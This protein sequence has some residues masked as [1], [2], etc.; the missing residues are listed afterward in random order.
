[1]LGIIFESCLVAH[2]TD[3]E[4]H[5]KVDAWMF[6]GFGALLV[7]LHLYF[8]G[9]SRKART[10]EF[11]KIHELWKDTWGRNSDAKDAHD[12]FLNEVPNPPVTDAK[13]LTVQKTGFSGC[14]AD[15][16]KEV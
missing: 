6:R 4:N 8:G 7:L 2:Y 1:M 3:D 13:A 16:E 9:R 10:E 14:C 15:Q 11:R 5:D 12:L